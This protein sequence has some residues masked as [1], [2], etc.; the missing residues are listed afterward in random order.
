MHPQQIQH[1]TARKTNSVESDKK[2]VLIKDIC[3]KGNNPSRVSLTFAKHKGNVTNKD[4]VKRDALQNYPAEHWR[5]FHAVTAQT[6]M[7]SR[8]LR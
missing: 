1:I 3:V 7:N 6:H 8:T 5:W 2:F 4:M